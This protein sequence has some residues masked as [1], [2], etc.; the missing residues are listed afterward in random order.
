MTLRELRPD[1]WDTVA[2]L[3]HAS[4]NDWYR[5]NLNR[6]IF[7]P[8]DPSSCRIFP[9]TYEALDPGCCL[10]AE[11]DGRLVGSCFY[12]PRET[13]ISLGIMNAHPEFAGRG[14]ARALL[15][16]ILRRAGEKPVR[17]VSSAMNLDS[18]SLYTRAGFVPVELYQDLALPAGT[19]L[20]DPPPG[21]GL[22]RNATA[23]DVERIV[24]LE[25]SISGI[26]RARDFAFFLENAQRCWHLSVLEREGELQGFL[27]SGPSMLGPGAMRD[28]ATALALI[29]A[30]LTRKHR[31]EPVFLLPARF[32][33]LV[34]TLYQWGA[35]NCELHVA[36]VRGAA[37]PFAGVTM[38]TFLPETG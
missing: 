38:P 15:E 27:A 34:R 7:P 18:Y 11:E 4:T 32:G 35:R 10:V 29:H 1:E 3:I 21:T 28:E 2:E 16:E 14:V 8:D 24:A 9:E 33:T 25:D 12:H 20:P 6:S 13:H 5:R 22:V 31:D 26:R 23:D 36:Q 30:A 19:P 17:L 37:P